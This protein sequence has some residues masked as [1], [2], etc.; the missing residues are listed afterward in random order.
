MLPVV[1]VYVCILVCIH[2]CKN[3]YVYTY[4]FICMYIGYVYMCAYIYIYIGIICVVCAQCNGASDTNN[5][6]HDITACQRKIFIPHV[7]SQRL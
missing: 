2:R 6:K 5:T 7:C 1:V 3:A 4:D